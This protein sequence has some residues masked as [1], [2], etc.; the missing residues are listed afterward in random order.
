VTSNACLTAF[1]GLVWATAMDVLLSPAVVAASLPKIARLNAQNAARAAPFTIRA[2]LAFCRGLITSAEQVV[3]TL[4]EGQSEEQAMRI[5]SAI[6]ELQTALCIDDTSGGDLDGKG[7]EGSTVRSG[8]TQKSALVT[9]GANSITK[10]LLHTRVVHYLFVS[11]QEILLQLN[12]EEQ[13]CV[14]NELERFL[15]PTYN[16]LSVL[17]ADQQQSSTSGSGKKKKNKNK[18]TDGI[19]NDPIEKTGPGSELLQYVRPLLSQSMQFPVN[20]LSR[21]A[22]TSKALSIIKASLISLPILISHEDDEDNTINTLGIESDSSDYHTLSSSLTSALVQCAAISI[23]ALTAVLPTALLVCDKVLVGDFSPITQALYSL[24]SKETSVFALRPIAKALDSNKQGNTDKEEDNET[25]AVLES[26][27][28]NSA[29]YSFFQKSISLNASTTTTTYIGKE[30]IS[31]SI[32]TIT[33]ASGSKRRRSEIIDGVVVDE[34]MSSVVTPIGSNSKTKKPKKSLVLRA[35]LRF[36]ESSSLPATLLFDHLLVG[37]DGK[38]LR[39]A[40]CRRIAATAFLRQHCVLVP[41]SSLDYGK[42]GGG[43]AYLD[44]ASLEEK[45]NTTDTSLLSD[46]NVISLLRIIQSLGAVS[47]QLVTVSLNSPVDNDNTAYD[48]AAAFALNLVSILLELSSGGAGHRISR[49]AAE[50]MRTISHSSTPSARPDVLSTSLRLVLSRSSIH[51]FFAS[52]MDSTS[53]NTFSISNEKLGQRSFIDAIAAILR[54]AS[55]PFAQ[56]SSFIRDKTAFAAFDGQTS[57]ALFE[58]ISSPFL[59][60]LVEKAS[61]ELLLSLKGDSA[62]SLLSLLTAKQQAIVLTSLSL[63]KV[64]KTA[65]YDEFTNNS[66]SIETKTQ[67]DA[68]RYEILISTVLIPLLTTSSPLTS[69]DALFRLVSFA[70]HVDETL[71]PSVDLFRQKVAQ[72]VV[73]ATSIVNSKSNL[74]SSILLPSAEKLSTFLISSNNGGLENPGSI[75]LLQALALSFTEVRNTLGDLKILPEVKKGKGM[76]TIAN[77]VTSANASVAGLAT[78]EGG[79]ES[80]IG[81]PKEVAVIFGLLP[82]LASQSLI[83]TKTMIVVSPVIALLA[84]IGTDESK[85]TMTTIDSS[86]SSSSSS[87]SLSAS[88]VAISG[89]TILRDSGLALLQHSLFPSSSIGIIDTAMMDSIFFSRAAVFRALRTKMTPL[90]LDATTKSVVLS[91]TNATS[92][93]SLSDDTWPLN[94]HLLSALEVTVAAALATAN[95]SAT[96][97]ASAKAS[98]SAD[99]FLVSTSRLLLLSVANL[100]AR[101]KKIKK[102]ST[103][104]MPTTV[105]LT[106]TRDVSTGGASAL[107]SGLTQALLQRTIFLALEILSRLSNSWWRAAALDDNKWTSAA[108][109]FARA[110][111]L[112]PPV[113]LTV[114]TTSAEGDDDIVNAGENDDDEEEEGEE[115]EENDD[116]DEDDTEEMNNDDEEEEEEEIIE[117]VNLASVSGIL[118]ILD[119]VVGRLSGCGKVL[120]R[121]VTISSNPTIDDVITAAISF[122]SQPSTQNLSAFSS[123]SAFI[124]HPSFLHLLLRDRY[125]AIP[126][127]AQGSVATYTTGGFHLDN[128]MSTVITTSSF[129]LSSL[130]RP[131]A[132]VLDLAIRRQRG[133][134]AASS[135]S[136]GYDISIGLPSILDSARLS[137]SR[138]LLRLALL[139]TPAVVTNSASLG[140]TQARR[141]NRPLWLVSEASQKSLLV[142]SFLPLLPVVCAAYTAS[143][144]PT[145]RLLRRILKLFETGSGEEGESGSSHPA[146]VGFSFSAGAV[147]HVFWS[148]KLFGWRAASRSLPSATIS[149]SSMEID[150]EEEEGGGGKINGKK[151]VDLDP[152]LALKETTA[153]A[154]PQLATSLEWFFAGEKEGQEGALGGSSNGASSNKFK[155]NGKKRGGFSFAVK[156]YQKG[157]RGGFGGRQRTSAGQRWLAQRAARGASSRVSALRL[158]A[159]SAPRMF[160]GAELAG[161]Q[162]GLLIAR[163]SASLSHFPVHRRFDASDDAIISLSSSSSSFENEDDGDT[164]VMMTSA[165]EQQRTESRV[166]SAA[167]AAR[168]ELA[169]LSRSRFGDDLNEFAT[170]STSSSALITSKTGGGLVG[171]TAE[172]LHLHTSRERIRATIYDPSFILPALLFVCA[173]GRLASHVKKFANGG[174]L[175]FALAATTS[176]DPTVRQA[177]YA[178]LGAYVEAATSLPE[179]AAIVKAL[180][181]GNCCFRSNSRLHIKVVEVLHD[182]KMVHMVV[183]ITMEVISKDLLPFE[184]Y[185][186]YLFFSR[187]LKTV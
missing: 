172:T 11:T 82:A 31:P 77:L 73:A 130:F 87:S 152:S 22:H 98:K 24:P 54:A 53:L 41:E 38:Y 175:T 119:A 36:L 167:R 72:A 52:C 7:G 146:R 85:T 127:L 42:G 113:A 154:N 155:N 16:L 1:S 66:V 81:P 185:H 160:S 55:R 6:G 165:T 169:L 187:V 10:L 145:D 25:T 139:L 101:T 120:S 163:V 4:G 158:A 153:S 74:V 161:A 132:L 106:S 46:H 117:G 186:K 99:R 93:T 59:Q 150:G 138:L 32:K 174:A 62:I 37:K 64:I 112:P 21:S 135:A 125:L 141:D 44:N 94:E 103:S 159:S 114:A 108:G 2:W 143:L 129:T 14:R 116:E 84:S 109:F 40:A 33:K 89:N 100:A 97:N 70:V 15:T 91:G 170:Q 168:Q 45:S 183:K 179:A 111:L 95:S 133:G 5:S 13:E 131:T 122:S 184:N 157:G 110:V 180:L 69:D 28:L 164:L 182:L 78:G 181:G 47:E 149:S 162:T 86:S 56:R 124:R 34:S 3:E 20:D 49:K 29:L 61:P 148:S 48:E 118:S 75:T 60:Q 71:C 63:S 67:E 23:D 102:G 79:N 26:L 123:L 51:S 12:K 43:L 121:D 30:T 105:I 147:S 166:V 96:G 17:S 27:P 177:A 9:A 178:V 57:A 90:L 137:S 19:T 126:G 58:Y 171:V 65:V 173:S 142:T 151:V 76:I 128:T 80:S 107:P 68:S 50:G 104:K 140:E 134:R 176:S 8:G 83:K 92:T 18:G 156:S 35:T 115:E 144:S 136:S 39:D 88:N